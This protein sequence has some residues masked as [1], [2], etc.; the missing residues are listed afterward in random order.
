MRSPLAWLA[1]TATALGASL[2]VPSWSA[3]VVIAQW[4]ASSVLIQYV[5][6]SPDGD[7]LVTADGGG[8]GQIWKLDGQTVAVLKGQR[9]PMFRAHFSGDG[10]SVI[11]TGYDGTGWV[12]MSTGGEPLRRLQLHRAATADAYL[13]PPGSARTADVV[14]GSDDGTVVISRADGQTLWSRQFSGTSRQ[15]R[16]SQSVDLIAASSD[17]GQLHLIS[18]SPDRRSATVRSIQTPHGRINLIRFN[19]TQPE[20]ATAGADGTI[21]L[22]PLDGQP[23]QRLVA[24]TKGWSRGVAYCAGTATTILGVGD[25][26]VL[27]QWSQRGQLLASLSLSPSAPL[28][29]VDCSPS[30]RQ[31][32]VVNGNGQLWLLSVNP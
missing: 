3:P 10:Q 26:G 11:T 22:I 23:Q 24:S 27:R 30:G 7:R 29:G 32:V 6:F 1:L 14:S 4:R 21:S 12:W 18:P 8:T 19:P 5:E 17:N 31:A 15:L 9:S 13:L 16:P 28:T 2:S 20:V 25:D